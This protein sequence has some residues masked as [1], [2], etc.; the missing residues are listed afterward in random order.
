MAADMADAV[1][2]TTEVAQPV[3]A[4]SICGALLESTSSW[5]MHMCVTWLVL[6][7]AMGALPA[8]MPG[9]VMLI[10]VVELT[11]HSP[12]LPCAARAAPG[13]ITANAAAKRSKHFVIRTPFIKGTGN[14]ALWRGIEKAA[15]LACYGHQK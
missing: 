13:S 5:L 15:R 12:A 10:S 8:P 6:G 11:V 14:L 9:M 7:I 3:D 4:S 2:E 1:D